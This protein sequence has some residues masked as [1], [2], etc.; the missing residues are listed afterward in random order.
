MGIRQEFLSVKI[1]KYLKPFFSGHTS[2][3][4]KLHHKRKGAFTWWNSIERKFGLPFLVLPILLVFFLFAGAVFAQ[5]PIH[6]LIDQITKPKPISQSSKTLP[7]SIQQAIENQAKQEIKQ[8]QANTLLATNTPGGSANSSA[9]SISQTPQSVS[10]FVQNIIEP[11]QLLLT[12]NPVDKARLRLKHIN[13]QIDELQLL[14]NNDKSDKAVNQAVSIVAN[15]GQ[16]TGLV[17]TDKTIQ[18]NREILTIQ[19]EQYNRL[20]LI[21]QK[22]EDTLPI[23]SYLKIED[24][25]V[26]HILKPAQDSL[27]GAPNLEAVNNIGTKEVRSIVGSDFAELKAIEILTDLQSGLKPQ[28]QQKLA[29]IQK[30]LVLQFE[31][32]MLKL[33]PDV[34]TRKLQAYLNLSYGNPI[35]QVRSFNQMQNLLTDREMILSVESL[36]ELALKKLEDRL[37]ELKTPALENQFNAKVLTDTSDIKI[38]IQAQLDIEAGKDVN[39]IKIIDQ[40]AARGQQSAIPIFGKNKDALQSAFSHNANPDVLDVVLVSRINTIL[41]NSSQVAPDIKQTI[42]QIKQKTLQNFVASI[43]KANFST[44]A[45]LSYNPVTAD[46]DVRLL[47]PA[48]HALPILEDIKKDLPALDQTKITIA[49]RANARILADHL[50]LQV[51][52]PAI[53]EQYQQYIASNSKVKQTI[54]NY[55][56][57]SFFAN[58]DKK[59]QIIDKQS[60]ITNQQLYEKMQ[61]IVQEVFLTKNTTGLE[62]EL[63]T[64]IQQELAVLKGELPAKSIPQ[65]ITPSDVKLPQVATLPSDVQDA[66]ITAAKEEIKFKQQSN[67][68]R[69]DLSTEAKDLGVSIPIILPDNPLYPLVNIIREIPIL[70][71]SDP[72]Q[73]AEELIKI[74]NEKTI[75]AAK[76]AI[77]NQSISSVDTAIKT[78]DSVKKDFD[79]LQA[80]ADQVKKVEQTEPAKVD[81]LVTQVIKDGVIRQTVISSIENNVYGDAYVAIEKIRQ[82]ILKDGVD[83][84]LAVTDNNVQKLTD[85]LENTVA[86]DTSSPITIVAGDIKAVELLTEIARTEPQ[87]AQKILQTG[88][89]TIAVSLEKTLLSQPAEI[90]AQ[91]VSSISQEATGNPVREFEALD[92]LKDDFKNPQTILLVEELKDK[93]AENLK[94]R[95]SEIPDA[96]TQ[97]TFADQVIGNMPQDLKAIT[98]IE[99]EVAPPQNAGIVVVLPVVQKVEDIKADIEQNIIDTY[100]DKPQDLAKTDFFTHNPT[101]DVVDVKVAQDLENALSSSSDVQ[102]EVV[103]VAKQEETKVIDTFVANVSKPEFQISVTASTNTSVT[104]Q[105]TSVVNTTTQTSVSAQT[106]ESQLAAETLN[107]IPETLA[108]LIDLKQQLPPTEQAKIDV[109]IN[110]EVRLIQDHLVNQVSDPSTFQTYVAQITQDP[111]VEA[112]VTK[113]GGQAFQQ[114]IEQKTQ[115]INQ[116]LKSDQA[117]LT[118]TVAQVQQEV[119]SAPVSSPSTVEQSLPQPIQQEIQQIKQEVPAQQI[120]AVNVA[121]ETS[122]STTVTAQPIDTTPI[123]APVVQQPQASAPAPAQP[124]APAVQA[125]APAA[126][127]PEAPAPQAQSA[128]E[129]PAAPAAPGL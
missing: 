21:L 109:A 3:E 11:L 44:Q 25:R 13:Q 32:R 97:N 104:T 105:P 7:S 125:P 69:L 61:Q 124:A 43:G 20:Q 84:L 123:A 81:Q 62:K 67:Q 14:I 58:L 4:N 41:N 93:T 66:L 8:G 49:E 90:R 122:V 36:K 42:N 60:K 127:A 108:E 106:N 23:S 99:A 115:T 128:P 100:K 94:E 107:P 95:I 22:V 27:N 75:E 91:E 119:F 78:L 46:A 56:P 117:Q 59:K 110:T 63:P 76:L 96:N 102:P 112:I 52:D 29:G 47:I 83:T 55:V 77:D 6:A 73:K 74:D 1:K 54:Q 65:L 68:A 121:T 26:K 113:V 92:V 88:E 71:T 114:A 34:R 85:K 111:A 33:P 31:K 2:E 35:N 80:N 40:M 48:P 18:T 89:A 16:E 45:K 87:A 10:P 64:S 103:V 39:K 38:L 37:F 53:F 120:P 28:T 70:L 30:E 129:Q 98:Q 51:N 24:A 79:I 118:T 72:V 57:Q 82:D 116:Q 50:L 5:A 126:P 15:I 17:V 101:P 12:A 9:I 19:I 86:P